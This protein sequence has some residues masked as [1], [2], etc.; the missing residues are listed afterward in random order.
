MDPKLQEMFDELRA[1]L[2]KN[3]D[4]HKFIDAIEKRVATGETSLTE[5]KAELKE[6]RANVETVNKAIEDVKRDA[7][8]VAQHRDGIV[9]K[10]EGHRILG[11]Q[12]R[13]LFF[14]HTGQPLP[15][16]FADEAKALEQYRATIY[17]DAGTGSYLIPTVTQAEIMDTL[18]VV[19]PLLSRCDFHTGL[20]GKFDMPTLIGRPTLRYKRATIDTAAAASDPTFGQFVFD[21]DE[22]YTYFPVDNRLLQMSAVAL[23]SLCVNLIRDGI[24]DGLSYGILRADGT[25][26]YNDM[27]GLLKEA[28]AGYISALPG[29]KTAFSDMTKADLSA[30]KGKALLRAQ[31][32]GVWLMGSYIVSLTEDLNRTGK[33]PV[34]T[35]RGDGTRLILGN[36]IVVDAYMPTSAESAI[37]TGFAVFG[38]LK[39]EFVGLVGGIDIAVSTEFMFNKNQT[40]FRGVINGQFQRKPFAGLITMKTPGA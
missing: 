6:L 13:Q 29:G 11:M 40:C 26:G 5:A 19:S 4:A 33:D 36:E 31:N 34:I 17:A 3:G 27:T 2:K 18:E 7:R 38:D 21:P 15:R 30:A 9:S 20:P 28:T 22:M 8:K 39:T 1:E 14:Q 12:L 32:I 37:S 25:S 10:Q 24:L 35:T 16:E 23:G